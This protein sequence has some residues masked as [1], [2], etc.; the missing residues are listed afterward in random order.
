MCA[1]ASAAPSAVKYP[2]ISNAI[3]ERKA[4]HIAATGADTAARRRS[5]LPDEHGGQA[6]R[7]GPQDRRAPR[8]RGA[9]R[10]ARATR[11]S[12]SAH[13]HRS[14]RP[15]SRTTRAP[16]SPTSSCSGRCASV[17]PDWPR[18]AAPRA[19]A[20]RSSR[21]CA[22]PAAT[23]RTTRWRTST[24]T[25]RSSSEGRARPAAIV[26]FAP[27]AEDARDDRARASAA[28][29]SARV[30]TKGKSMI[31]EEIGLNDRARERRHRGRSRPI[32]ANTS[33]RSAARRRATSSRRP[34]T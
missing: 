6:V 28:R 26:H 29:R 25:W 9:G 18:D 5:R 1:A 32:S 30:V 33:S 2:D 20:C 16:R 11:R 24:S 13:E 14:R 22:T 23:S 10:R 21:R 8:G 12:A 4:E 31:S 27:T 17:A 15:P 34:S 7:A 3:V 19:P